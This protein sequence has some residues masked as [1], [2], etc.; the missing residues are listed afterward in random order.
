M[1]KIEQEAQNDNV[2]KLIGAIEKISNAWGEIWAGDSEVAARRLTTEENFYD[3]E[4]GPLGQIKKMITEGSLS[5]DDREKLKTSLNGLLPT[6][7]GREI[8]KEVRDIL[9]SL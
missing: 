8:Q 3:F 1:S 7:P 6:S 5:T 9:R 2:S 4:N